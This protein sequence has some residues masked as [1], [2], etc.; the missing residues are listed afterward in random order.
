[1]RAREFMEAIP[2]LGKTAQGLGQA[3]KTAKTMT[4]TPNMDKIIFLIVIIR[5]Q[6]K[7]EV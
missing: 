3:I 2:S 6:L 5:L 7:S 1:M 4:K